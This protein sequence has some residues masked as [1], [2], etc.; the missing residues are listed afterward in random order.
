MENVQSPY[1]QKCD[2]TSL[3]KCSRELELLKLQQN[4]EGVFTG[5]AGQGPLSWTIAPASFDLLGTSVPQAPDQKE[6]RRD[7][8]RNYCV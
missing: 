6:I 2:S 4:L 5:H 1:L 7:G 8:E 3:V